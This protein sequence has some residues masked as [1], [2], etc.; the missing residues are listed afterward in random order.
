MASRGGLARGISLSLSVSLLLLLF[1]AAAQASVGDRLPSF[2]ECLE[3]CQ[4]ENCGSGKAHTPIP[5]LHRILLW[6]CASE[7]DYTCQHIITDQRIASAEPVVQF[8]GKWPFRRFL[9]MQEP[10]SVLFSLGNLWAHHDGLRKIRARV[11]STYTLRPFYIVLAHVGMAS[12]FF[13]AL[14]HTRD[15]QATEE[16]DYFAAGANV[17]YGLYYTAV[18]IFRLDRPSAQ[19]RSALRAWTAMCLVLYLLHVAYLKGVRWDYT[20]NM[21]A[22][23]VV[24]VAQ[25][26]LWTWF[27]VT[28]YQ[29]SKSL[30]SIVPVAVVAWVMVA[31][32]MELFDFPPWLG[33]ID[34]H[35]LWHLMTIGPTVLMYNFLL[36]DTQDTMA[37][38]QRYKA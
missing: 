19:R 8:H 26:I 12:W 36:K 15:F 14:F 24:G 17:L 27:S 32:S 13:S 33:C 35:S 37:G 16:L 1:C 22:N 3:V 9:G 11:P 38:T 31:M 20:Y 21:A 25:N 4:A 30:W 29:K 7:C 2:R 10:F 5:L 18:R 34:A 28:S 6:D 23:V